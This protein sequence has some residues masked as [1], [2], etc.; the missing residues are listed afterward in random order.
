MSENGARCLQWTEEVS[1]EEIPLW[2]R[3]ER[4]GEKKV[5]KTV[6]TEE[7]LYLCLQMTST[8]SLTRTYVYIA[9]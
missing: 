7:C 3:S 8:G 9:G 2:E 4:S 1:E 5:G 6:N